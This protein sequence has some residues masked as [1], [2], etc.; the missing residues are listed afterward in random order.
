MMPIELELTFFGI[1]IANSVA[2][3]Y[4]IWNAMRL[5]QKLSR[6]RDFSAMGQKSGEVRRQRKL[7]LALARDIV[8]KI[9]PAYGMIFDYVIDAFPT[10]RKAIE[11]NPAMVETLLG[12][13]TGKGGLNIGSL[14]GQQLG[15]NGNSPSPEVASA[16]AEAV[17]KFEEL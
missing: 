15:A 4:F 3:A 2:I 11:K 14:L 5:Q 9:N 7:N 17:K 10:V 1:T 6:F 8:T 12:M 16:F 13:L